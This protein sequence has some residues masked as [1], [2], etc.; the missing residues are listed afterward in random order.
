MAIIFHDISNPLAALVGKIELAQL[1]GKVETFDLSLMSRMVGHISSI[2]R[3]A[4]AINSSRLD[5]VIRET[6]TTDRIDG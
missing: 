5:T 4:R 2:I 3:I 1:T 6:G